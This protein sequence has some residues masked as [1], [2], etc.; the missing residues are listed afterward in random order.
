MTM[1]IIVAGVGGQG[2]IMTSHILAETAIAAGIRDVRVGETYGAAMRGG[3]VVSHVRIG[4]AYAPLMS[5]DAAELMIVLEPLEGLRYGVK[6]LASGGKVIL[7]DSPLY[8]LDTNMGNARY[9]D[10]KEVVG[11]LQDLGGEVTVIPAR[12]MSGK[13]GTIRVLSTIMLGAA[14]GSG[15]LKLDKDLLV[16]TVR[17]RVPPKTVEMNMRAFQAGYDFMKKKA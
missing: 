9:P 6:Y 8:T 7:S 4:E 3:S 1:N 12:A 14:S 17:N 16:E 5:E 15:Y 13:I 10:L 2:S 11:S